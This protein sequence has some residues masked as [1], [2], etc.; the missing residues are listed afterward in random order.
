MRNV[1]RLVLT[2]FSITVTSIVFSQADN[3][4]LVKKVSIKGVPLEAEFSSI[5][6]DDEGFMWMGGL[7]GLYR[8]DGSRVNRFLRDPVRL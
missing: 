1:H 6:Q 7:S 8:Y 5:Q 3:K 2:L 4:F